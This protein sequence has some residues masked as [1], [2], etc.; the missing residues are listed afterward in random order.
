MPLKPKKTISERF[1][2]RYQLVIRREEN[3]EE[4]STIGFTYRQL[5][6]I[7]FMAFVLIFALSL[8]LS[9]S[10]LARWFD[11]RFAQRETEKKLY[12]LGLRVDS[13][14][15][16]EKTAYTP[17]A[18]NNVSSMNAK[19]DLEARLFIRI[20]LIEQHSRPRLCIELWRT[21]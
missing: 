20:I 7:G 4:K 8:Y 15:R 14:A 5:M 21:N 9:Q 16:E 12:H 1:N 17:P 11:P 19:I 10:L 6:I 3:L 13:L 18:T 2:E